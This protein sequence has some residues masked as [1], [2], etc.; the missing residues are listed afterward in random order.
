MLFP[1]FPSTKLQDVNLDWL[2]KKICKLRGGTTNQVLAKASDADFD[3]KWVTGG[4]GGGTS[5]YND[6][7]NQPKINN[8]TLVGNVSGSDLGLLDATAL[9]NYR[10]A[11]DQDAI[12]AGKQDKITASG[13]LKGDGDGGVTA[14]TAGTDYLAPAALNSYR[15]AA[16]QDTIDAGKQVKITASGILKGDGD[17]GVAAATAGTDYLAPAALND[18]RTAAA[19]DLLDAAQDANVGI[20]ITGAR[21][22]RTVTAG[23]Y[24]IVR[25]STIENIQDGI[26]KAKN[27]LSTSVDVTASELAA[28]S[29]GGL[30]AIPVPSFLVR[31]VAIVNTQVSANSYAD[32]T[33]NI[34]YTGWR[35][36]GIVG[37]NTSRSYLLMF[38]M[39]IINNTT[40]RLRVRNINSTLAETESA[41]VQVLYVND[42]I[43]MN[44]NGG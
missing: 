12:D 31:Q 38:G 28:L 17:G 16:N 40:A 18:Y 24:V 1:K 43:D 11:A 34:T 30:N 3:F 26:Y 44:N 25:N 33:T 9:E 22:S 19:Q 32:L 36:L 7:V 29:Q 20:V 14:A 5:D 35:P 10:T 8:V 41:F 21:P 27:N 39:N 13:M 4:G 37:F 2:L 42:S 6:L 23:Q 15:T